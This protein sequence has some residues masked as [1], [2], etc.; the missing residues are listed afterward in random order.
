MFPHVQQCQKLFALCTCITYTWHLTVKQSAMTFHT[1]G[2]TTTD[3]TWTGQ[4]AHHQICKA[5]QGAANPDTYRQLYTSTT[6]ATCL[7]LSH[8][9]CNPGAVVELSK[10][11]M[12]DGSLHAQSIPDPAGVC[13]SFC[14]SVARN[15]TT[16]ST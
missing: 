2:V 13:V 15:C 3:A 7:I 4:E 16:Q 5:I 8:I 1:P 14:L 12:A 11:S 10:T 9:M 6:E